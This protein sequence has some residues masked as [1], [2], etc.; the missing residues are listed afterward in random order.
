[1]I[2]DQTFELGRFTVRVRV[3]FDNPAWPVYLVFV[4]SK[5][6]GKSFS[7]PDIGCCEWLERQTREE[8]VYAEASAPLPDKGRANSIRGSAK[9][10]AF[11]L[12]SKRRGFKERE[13]RAFLTI[14][15]PEEE[16]N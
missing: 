4:A 11:S 13:H 1:M 5:F 14:E 7:R 2:A 16:F 6:V 10:R 15:A 8:L 12:S 3:R 9:A